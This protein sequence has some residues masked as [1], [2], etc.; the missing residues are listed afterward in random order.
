MKRRGVLFDLDGVLIDSERLYSEF[1]DGIAELY[2]TGEEN[3]SLAI[4]GSTIEKI[5]AK[6]FPSPEASADDQSVRLCRALL[7]PQSL[8]RAK[9]APQRHPMR[10]LC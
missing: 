4:K 6:Y 2:D 9:R 5:L 3:F 7:R 8:R 1:Y 10:S